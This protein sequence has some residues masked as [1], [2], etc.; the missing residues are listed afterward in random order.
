LQLDFIYLLPWFVL[1]TSAQNPNRAATGRTLDG[2]A[3]ALL[4][5]PIATDLPAVKKNTSTARLSKP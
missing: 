2:T 3:A 4:Q 1:R 5:R